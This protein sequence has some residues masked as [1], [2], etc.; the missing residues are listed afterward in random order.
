MLAFMTTAAS[1]VRALHH[2]QSSLKKYCIRQILGTWLHMS[3][4]KSTTASNTCRRELSTQVERWQLALRI[5]TGK[6]QTQQASPCHST[7]SSCS[8]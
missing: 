4:P 3:R 5:T 7:H 1:K 6:G 2:P 8:C